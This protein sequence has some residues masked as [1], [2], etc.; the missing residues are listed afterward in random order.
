MP[1]V[2]YSTVIVYR[3]YICIV[4]VHFQY[5]ICVALRK[6]LNISY[7]HIIRNWNV[8]KIVL[9]MIFLYSCQFNTG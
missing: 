7:Y 9:K 1:S 4:Y 6:R 5:K 3:L 2:P 8:Y